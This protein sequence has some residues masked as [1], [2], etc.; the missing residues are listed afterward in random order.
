MAA[1]LGR[2][3]GLCPIPVAA[4]VCQAKSSTVILLSFQNRPTMPFKEFLSICFVSQEY[5]E[6][7]G[8]GGIGTYTYEMAHGLARLG[9]KVVV[10]SRA[11]EQEQHYTEHDGVEVYRVLP[12]L[13]V[14]ATPV[15]WRLNRWWEGYRL[16]VAKKLKELVREK[17]IDVIESPEL[18]AEPLLF[19]LTN[20]RTPLVVRLHSG[21]RVVSQFEPKTVSKQ[22]GLDQRAESWLI[23]RASLVTSPSQALRASLNGE[24]GTRSLAVIPNPVD[25]DHFKPNSSVVVNSQPNILCVG[26]PRPIK[27]IHVLAKAMPAIWQQIPEARFT[28]VPAPMGKNGGSPVEEYPEFLGSL[29][30]DPRVQI[31]NAVSRAELPDIYRG[32]TVCV[33]PSLWEGFGY[34][35]AEAMACGVPVVA[36]RIGGLA[37]IVED[38]RSGVLVEPGDAEKLAQAVSVLIK[39]EPRRAALGKNARERISST[40]STQVVVP[41]MAAFYETLT[42]NRN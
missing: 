32:S 12:S 17:G 41:T 20:A 39:D 19:S 1:G 31:V 28:F 14:D 9:H 11:L 3:A 7:T 27:G 42:G 29:I 10:L 26:R 15:I 5:P 33:V 8:W 37:E 21:S 34:V 22:P 30:D 24:L 35:A 36:S 16:A 25:I 23:R 38:G 4:R 6:E 2:C 13:S 40:F 18:H